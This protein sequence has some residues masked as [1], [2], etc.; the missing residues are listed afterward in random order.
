[1]IS[2]KRFYLL[3]NADY[4]PG[5]APDIELFSNDELTKKER[6]MIKNGKFVELTTYCFPDSIGTPLFS[7][8]CHYIT[9]LFLFD[10]YMDHNSYDVPYLIQQINN[11]VST[12]SDRHQ[13][14]S[15]HD[16]PDRHQNTS[17]HD[18]P[19]RHQNTSFHDDKYGRLLL[20]ILT[21]LPELEE[22]VI[23]YLRGIG[24]VK[25][26]TFDEYV[27]RR[28]F[29]SAVYTF[30]PMAKLIDPSLTLDQKNVFR[31]INLI[32]SLGNDCFSYEKEKDIDEISSVKILMTNGYTLE[33]AVDFIYEYI[34]KEFND[35]QKLHLSN[36]VKNVLDGITVWTFQ[37][38]RYKSGT[39]PFSELRHLE[40]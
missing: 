15:F 1:M 8:F 33:S 3:L 7:H 35:L 12:D 36:A 40:P 26:E 16:D 14:T 39:S 21:N 10:D 32:I 13:N 18:D 2:L 34:L 24:G 22:T 30:F 29:D 5:I 23:E 9:W 19:D 28:M 25:G 20:P 4:Q 31:K 6:L 17:F 37:S 27:E 38:N 11:R